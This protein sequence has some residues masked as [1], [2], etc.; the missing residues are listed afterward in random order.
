M[1]LHP[2]LFCLPFYLLYFVLPSFEDNGLPFWVPDIFCQ[3]SEV[4]LW[5]SSVFKC[6]FDQFVGQKVVS[7]SYSSTVLGPPP[8]G[9]SISPCNSINF[10]FMYFIAL[11]LG[12]EMS[13]DYYILLI[14]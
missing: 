6:S 5:K 1:D 9:F 13:L 10:H 11:L 4:V 8:C 14:N 2:Y 12:E 7:P 3:H